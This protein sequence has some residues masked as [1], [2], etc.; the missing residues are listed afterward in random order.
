MNRKNKVVVLMLGFGLLGG[1][2]LL[3]LPHA[4]K[5]QSDAE[6]MNAFLEAV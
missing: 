6:I 4:R 3:L 2:L 1:T 5:P